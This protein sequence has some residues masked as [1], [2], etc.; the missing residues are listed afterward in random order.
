MVE[1]Q[2][3]WLRPSVK[4]VNVSYKTIH[5]NMRKYASDSLFIS[6]VIQKFKRLNTKLGDKRY[7]IIA[8]IAGGS[9]EFCMV[10]LK[11]RGANYCKCN[12]FLFV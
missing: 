6:K 2:Q 1:I 5:Q 11:V 12:F 7:S 8:F 3:T 4:T 9:I 10:N